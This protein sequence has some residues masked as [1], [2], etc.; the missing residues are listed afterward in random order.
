MKIGI[1]L[2]PCGFGW[3]LSQEDILSCCKADIGSKDSFDCKLNE[4]RIKPYF[5]STLFQFKKEK[6][7]KYFSKKQYQINRLHGDEFCH[8][9]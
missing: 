4:K 1:H 9:N 2:A 7:I 5:V 8:I 3:F 6:K